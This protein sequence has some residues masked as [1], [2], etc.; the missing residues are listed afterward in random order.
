MES[1]KINF[2]TCVYITDSSALKDYDLY[3]KYYYAV[4]TQYRRA[5]DNLRRSLRKRRALAAIFLFKKGLTDLGVRSDDLKIEFDNNKQYVTNMD[6]LNFQVS[7]SGDVVICA[8]ASSPVGCD[9]EQVKVADQRTMED[10]LGAFRFD[11]IKREG[12][13]DAR[14]HLFFKMLALDESLRRIIKMNDLEMSSDIG[15]Y[16]AGNGVHI[17]KDNDTG[18]AFYCKEYEKEY[19]KKYGNADYQIAC[20]TTSQSFENE[21]RII[22]LN[23]TENF[24]F[25]YH[26]V[27]QLF[28]G[29]EKIIEKVLE[30]SIDFGVF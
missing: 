8:F 28:H 24:T 12:N 2:D 27:E 20:C 23:E 5:L 21:C 19:E 16:D 30:N 25:R 14:Q 1:G 11:M 22:D 9:V 10:R 4:P 6:D 13:Q 15:H 17:I 18:N 7:Y 29:D 3:N 26:G